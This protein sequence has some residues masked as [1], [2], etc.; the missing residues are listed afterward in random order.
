MSNRS[1]ASEVHICPTIHAHA[2]THTHTHKLVACCCRFLPEDGGD[3]SLCAEQ[4][5]HS[6]H[7]VTLLFSRSGPSENETLSDIARELKYGFSLLQV[8]ATKMAMK[9]PM[10]SDITL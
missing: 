10:F 5:A 3:I 8:S 9:I 4:Y 6:R 2:H 1:G 7:N